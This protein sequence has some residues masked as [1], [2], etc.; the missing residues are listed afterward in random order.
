[1]FNKK[2]P[3]KAQDLRKEEIEAIFNNLDWASL[4]RE[5]SE[6]GLLVKY[7]SLICIILQV[8]LIALFLFKK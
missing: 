8:I 6:S 1:M 5:E 7:G 4:F 2:E 3:A